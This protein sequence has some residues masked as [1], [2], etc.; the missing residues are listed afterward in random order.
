MN[1]MS[2][3]YPAD[4]AFVSA[5]EEHLASTLRGE[6]PGTVFLGGYQRPAAAIAMSIAETLD[7]RTVL[8]RF[9]GDTLLIEDRSGETYE[10]QASRDADFMELVGA[11][12]ATQV[13]W[14]PLVAAFAGFAKRLSGWLRADSSQQGQELRNAFHDLADGDQPTVVVIENMTSKLWLLDFIWSTASE[15]VNS[16]LILVAS[17]PNDR[18]S[19]SVVQGLCA[20]DLAASLVMESVDEAAVRAWA[21]NLDDEIRRGALDLSGG[22]PELV[23]ELCRLLPST[24]MQHLSGLQAIV[25]RVLIEVLGT[26][27]SDH[28]W[29]TDVLA[30]GALVG[31]SFSVIPVSSALEIDLDE[32][33]DGLD[34]RLC[35][36][37]GRPQLL[38]SLPERR[39]GTGDW[40][41]RFI[42]P[43]IA[44]LMRRQFGPKRKSLT[45]TRLVT[46]MELVPDIDLYPS[47]VSLLNQLGRESDAMEYQ[48][49]LDHAR[50]RKAAEVLGPQLLQTSTDR[51]QQAD[52]A[53]AAVLAI[54]YGDSL[55]YAGRPK[56]A[57]EFFRAA[58]RWSVAGGSTLHERSARRRIIRSLCMQHL[59]QEAFE[60]AQ[61]SLELA[62][63]ASGGEPWSPEERAALLYEASIVINEANSYPT[64]EERRLL[65]EALGLVRLG[66][67]T[68]FALLHR[69]ANL[70]RRAGQKR[71]AWTQLRECL[72]YAELET[73]ERASSFLGLARI[74]RDQQWGRISWNLYSDALACY[75]GNPVEAQLHIRDVVLIL[76][77]RATVGYVRSAFRP[78]SY[79]SFKQAVD[80]SDQHGV[81]ELRDWLGVV[82]AKLDGLDDDEDGGV[83]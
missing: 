63:G 64:W 60:E 26:D 14:L 54:E 43:W 71:S 13:W 12:G 37:G 72:R 61:S 68:Y 62:S 56:E 50:I 39:P 32:T 9:E 69:S 81:E 53:R 41:Y 28:L 16:S 23:A 70:H 40:V 30:T 25:G 78:Q 73:P 65:D 33:I 22:N 44:E 4:R 10:I 76:G 11:I 75:E 83:W 79:L 27:P 55:N 42:Q 24:D 80:L 59:Y 21:P 47:I 31:D 45:M 3:P 52:Y 7:L 29:A 34:D 77:E 18:E 20:R 8:A 66:T 48:A 46:A 67:Y 74:A 19:V 6:S 36:A 58:A 57:G 82:K 15:L 49:A 51:W 38:V 35:G 17:T 1:T 5:L 2:M